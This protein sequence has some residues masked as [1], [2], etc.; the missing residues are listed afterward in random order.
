[1]GK[2]IPSKYQQKIFDVF[3]NTSDNIV[4]Q[5]VAGSGKS[6]TLIKLLDFVPSDKNAIFIAFNR[7]IVENLKNKIS[8]KHNV[9]IST[10]NS[11]GARLLYKNFGGISLVENKNF[12]I[13]LKLYKTKWEIKEPKW[14]YCYIVSKIV[15]IM[16]FTLCYEDEELISSVCNEY[17]ITIFNKELEHA[18]EVFDISASNINQ[19]DFLDQIFV[20]VIRK[21]KFIRHDYVFADE[22]QDFSIL[23]HKFIQRLLKPGIGRLISVGDRNQ[24]IYKFAGADGNSF[25][26][27]KNLL[28]NT[29]ELP[30]SI[31][32]RCSQEV[33]KKAKT[34]VSEIEVHPKAVKGI[35]RK[36]K[37]T[38]EI[39]AGDAVICRLT[40]PLILL[41]R[42][43]IRQG[44]KA[45]IKGR[46]IGEN[47]ITLIKKTK[48]LTIEGCIEKIT[49]YQ[50]ELRQKLFKK[51]CP[52]PDQHAQ[53]LIL[54]E[55]KEIIKILSQDCQTIKRLIERIG[56]IFTDVESDGI[57]L[58]TGHKA[59]GLEFNRVFFL[60]S[61]LL[62]SP[63]AETE[64]ELQQEKN[65]EYVIITRSKNELIYIDIME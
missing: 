6:T 61:F 64:I 56:E 13:A 20:P 60:N 3:N 53:M 12:L 31:C 49:G 5:A 37:K 47:L 17:G 59:K 14:S 38:E 48:S 16:R 35:V 57:L 30:L 33:V 18:Q 45:T 19:V 8:H 50:F 28:P 62:P 10:I 7:H 52:Y 25:D 15:D 43:L 40:R 41:F 58:M 11:F 1:M 44:K 39:Q 36:T 29:Q 65:L 2:F 51:G 54:I 4:I 46:E 23:Q 32:Y 24:A 63:Y 27:L 34:I 22:N 26:A 42:D 9:Q 55:K 21:L